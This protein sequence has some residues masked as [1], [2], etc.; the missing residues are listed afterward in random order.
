MSLNK[1]NKKLKEIDSSISASVNEFNCLVLS[2]LVD[3]YAKSVKAAK[4]S[5]NQKKYF[6]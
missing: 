1:L 3:D 4:I 6:H 2:G 5:L